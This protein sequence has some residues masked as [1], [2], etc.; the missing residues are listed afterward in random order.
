MATNFNPEVWISIRAKEPEFL[1]F[2]GADTPQ[3]AA[4]TALARCKD[5]DG[6]M[7]M[8]K[9]EKLKSEFLADQRTKLGLPSNIGIC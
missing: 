2:M 8:Q 5:A 4:V 9:A 7:S 6:A 3:E 1:A